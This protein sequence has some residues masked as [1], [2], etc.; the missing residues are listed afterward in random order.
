MRREKARIETL[1]PRGQPIPDKD[2][3]ATIGQSMPPYP[4][5]VSDSALLQETLELLLH[6]GGRAPSTTIAD[7]VF[8]ISNLDEDLASLL[9]AD[10]CAM[11]CA[12]GAGRTHYELQTNSIETGPW[13]N[14]SL[15]WLMS[16]PLAPNATEPDY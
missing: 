8:K 2:S 9:V 15:S 3:R 7:S 4:N 1:P 5:L 13:M 6:S 16:R 12:Q 14:S 10:L 11:I